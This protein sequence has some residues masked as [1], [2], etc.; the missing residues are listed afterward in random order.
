ML[1]PGRVPNRW[2]DPRA[3]SLPQATLHDLLRPGIQQ[4]GS[5]TGLA[6]AKFQSVTFR[7]L[8]AQTDDLALTAAGQQQQADDVRL[9][10]L[11]RRAFGIPVEDPVETGDLL[12]RE[13]RASAPAVADHAGKSGS[14]SPSGEEPAESAF[15]APVACSPGATENPE[16]AGGNDAGPPPEPGPRKQGSL[17]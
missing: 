6:I 4:H 14:A 9:L 1:M 8:T 16:R 13:A 3:V 17:L 10:G 7:L 5:R 15:A 12:L 11:R 2:K